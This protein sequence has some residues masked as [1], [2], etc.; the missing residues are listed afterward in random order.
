[1]GS[2]DHHICEFPVR[3][4]H[5]CH[6]PIYVYG[7]L[8]GSPEVWPEN[9]LV[10]DNK[11]NLARFSSHW[12]GELIATPPTYTFEDTDWAEV[13]E[14][15]FLKFVDKSGPESVRAGFSVKPRKP[16]GKS[17]FLRRCYNEGSLIAQQ[18]I[19][20]VKIQMDSHVRRAQLVA[21]SNAKMITGYVQYGFGDIINDN[22]LHGPLIF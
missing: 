16:R 4:N 14:D 17:P 21:L 3:I 9:G 10:L 6:G 5:E 2:N 18:R 7:R 1:M 11:L 15:V 22:S 20:G 13:P 12:R 19:D 8:N